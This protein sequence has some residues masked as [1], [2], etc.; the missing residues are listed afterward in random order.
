MDKLLIV[1]DEEAMRRLLRINLADRYEIVDTGN[2]DQALAMALQGKPNAI[3][4]DLR[5]P[6]YSG[7]ELCQTFK[8]MT[9]TQL[10]PIV[11][12][13]GEAGATTKLF[14][15]ELGATAYFEKPVDFDALRAGLERVLHAAQPERRS[16]LRVRLQVTLKLRGTDVNEKPFEEVSVTEN[17]SKSAFFCGCRALVKKESTIEVYLV[18]GEMRFVGK[19]RLVR[20][21]GCDTP[22]PRYAFRFVQKAGDWILQ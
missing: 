3:L 10:I 16:E 21:E 17:V 6:N 13:S 22:Y 7:F 15:K 12:I 4:L 8:S 11:I 5:M 1:D 20:S 2:S 18:K 9:S 19:A 14:C